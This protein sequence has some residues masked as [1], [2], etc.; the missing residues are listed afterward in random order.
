MKF[1][2]ALILAIS[3]L[4]STVGIAQ[5]QITS[6]SSNPTNPT[7]NIPPPTTGGTLDIGSIPVGYQIRGG[8]IIDATIDKQSNSITL[9]VNGDINA[10][11]VTGYDTYYLELWLP[12]RLIDTAYGGNFIV[13]DNSQIPAGSQDNEDKDPREVGISYQA[14]QNIIKITGTTISNSV[15]GTGPITQQ[16]SASSQTNPSQ[17]QFQLDTQAIAAIVTILAVVGGAVVGIYHKVF[18]DKAKLKFEVTKSYLSESNGNGPALTIEMKIHNRGAAHTTVHGFV[19]KLKS[20]SKEAE[21][22]DDK[23]T[24]EIDADR[25]I[26]KT[27][28]FSLSKDKLHIDGPIPNEFT[29]IIRHTNGEEKKAHIPIDKNPQ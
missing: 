21:I 25:T 9:Q 5:A 14:G 15:N 6:S 22:N 11:T 28:K 2:V 18:R 3:F 20:G 4:F 26:P 16:N 10:K 1:T 17:P 8:T 23:D 27:V 12:H 29:L 19:C 7:Q 13:L 24:V